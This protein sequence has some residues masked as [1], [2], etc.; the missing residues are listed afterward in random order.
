MLLISNDQNKNQRCYNDF[1]LFV[2]FPMSKKVSD[3]FEHGLD[4]FNV[5]T[6]KWLDKR[7]PGLFAT[8]DTSDWWWRVF[9]RYL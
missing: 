7:K 3:I 8:L 6:T 2:I 1:L 4:S 9:G 5:L